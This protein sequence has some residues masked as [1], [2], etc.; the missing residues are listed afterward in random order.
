MA[1]R[2]E[3]Q[4]FIIDFDITSGGTSPVADLIRGDVNETKGMTLIRTI[5]RLDI[6]PAAPGATTDSTQ[7]VALGIGMFATAAEA[8]GVTALASPSVGTDKPLTG[9]LWRSHGIVVAEVSA[10]APYFIINEDI[11]AK[12]KVMYGAPILV[13]SNLQLTNTAFSVTVL[14]IIRCLYLQD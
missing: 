5:I 14:G 13:V 12:R 6:S 4:D 11:R 3:W 10:T 1:R 9:W 7:K 2:T 8:I